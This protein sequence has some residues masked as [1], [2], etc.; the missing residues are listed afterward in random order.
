MNTII[1]IIIMHLIRSPVIWFIPLSKV[2]SSFTT[3]FFLFI[4]PIN[5]SSPVLTTTPLITL[6]PIK[7]ILFI[8]IG[9]VVLVSMLIFFSTAALS[10]VNDDW[11][12][13]KSLLSNKYRSAGITLP[14]LK[15]IISP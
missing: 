4:L 6:H 11:L 13:N 2:V 12:I 1:Q 10:P 5:V 9:S 8:S 7:H 15:V 14:A 3:S